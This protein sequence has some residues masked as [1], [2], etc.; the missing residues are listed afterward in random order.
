M[1]LLAS[2]A[3]GAGLPGSMLAK[4]WAHLG[5]IIIDMGW[6]PEVLLS[7]SVVALG[8]VVMLVEFRTDFGLVSIDHKFFL[9]HF[10]LIL[11]D[12][13]IFKDFVVCKFVY[14]SVLDGLAR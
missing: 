12:L 3:V 2:E 1:S 13:S 8:P 10:F 11:V 7:V 5:R 6:S 14:S 4:I 9:V